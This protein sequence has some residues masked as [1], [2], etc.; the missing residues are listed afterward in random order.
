MSNAT[1]LPRSSMVVPVTHQG[2]AGA[3]VHMM[4]PIGESETWTDAIGR[5]WRTIGVASVD[6]DGRVELT[7]HY[8]TTESELDMLRGFGFRA[9]F[10]PLGDDTRT[11]QDDRWETE[12]SR[13]AYHTN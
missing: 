1:A 2:L 4:V 11:W 9:L 13:P 3:N 7:P 12:V 5:A 10:E 8:D 6:D